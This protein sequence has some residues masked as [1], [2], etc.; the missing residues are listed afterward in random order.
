M[1]T[2]LA[3][4]VLLAAVQDPAPKPVPFAGTGVK[5]VEADPRERHLRN[6]RQLTYEGENAEAYWNEDASLIVFQHRGEGIPADQVYT[7]KPDGTG[8]RLASTGTGK[9]TCAYFLPGGKRVLFASTHGVSEKPPAPPD[10]SRGYVWLLHP[11]YDLWSADLDG[12]DLKRVTDAPGY[13]AE[14]VLSPDGKRI[15]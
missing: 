2:A 10:M 6:V 8:L 4:I 11:E 1:R 15:V 3:A 13:D 5:S 12:K 14:A 7:V 9:C